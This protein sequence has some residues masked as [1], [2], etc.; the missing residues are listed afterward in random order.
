M[1]NAHVFYQ[2]F[3]ANKGETISAYMAMGRAIEKLYRNWYESNRNVV[4][5]YYSNKKKN[6]K[7]EQPMNTY[8]KWQELEED[9]AFWEEKE[10]RKK[11]Q[12]KRKK[13]QNH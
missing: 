7:T 3:T 5:M 4:A 12:Q 6:K 2:G 1:S 10:K 8:E 13:T 11:T 9:K